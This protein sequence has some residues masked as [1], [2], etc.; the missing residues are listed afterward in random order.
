MKNIENDENSKLPDQLF[1]GLANH[2][3]PG[4]L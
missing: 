1:H 3:C 2:L 4:K